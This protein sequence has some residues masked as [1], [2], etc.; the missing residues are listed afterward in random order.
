MVPFGSGVLAL[1]ESEFRQA[2]ER[3]RELM[4]SEQLK[5]N[6]QLLDYDGCEAAT[7]VPRSWWKESART[8]R[9][10]SYQ[11]GLYK[12]IDLGDALKAARSNGQ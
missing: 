7:G 9:I 5:S 10:P 1:E 3:G 12:R 8:G 2:L 4:P 11:F 6:R